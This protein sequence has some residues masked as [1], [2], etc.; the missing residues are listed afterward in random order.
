MEELLEHGGRLIHYDW[1]EFFK[2]VSL[3][4]L[5]ILFLL[6]IYDR[7]VQ[8]HNQLLIN[9][10]LIGRMRYLFTMLREP[11]RQYFGDEKFY[12]SH[13]KIDWV[14]KA[15]YGKKLYYSF[16]LTK[17][18]KKETAKFV[19][20]NM[21]LNQSEVDENFQVTF[22]E[23]QKYPFTTKSIIGRSAMSD[24]SISPEATQ[25]FAKGAYMGNFPINTGEGSLTTNF[26]TTHACS[27][28]MQQKPYLEVHS[29]TF[30][31]KGIYHLTKFFFN[32][33]IASNLYRSLVLAK[34]QE[35]YNF[36]ERVLSFYRVD[37]SQPLSAFP[38]EVC[39]IPD[40]IF[41]MGSGLYGV[42]D[43]EGKFDAL[44]YQKVMRFCK[45]TE[46]KIA[47]G[48]KQTGG[49]L[50]AKKVTEAIAYYRGIPA[51]QDIISPNRFPYAANLTELF[52]FVGTLQSLSKTRGHQ[53][54]HLH[55]S[56][57]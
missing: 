47:Q 52:D 40:I 9:Y 10:P 36:D 25:A 12:D 23:R 22:G 50:L 21:V 49:K 15:S 48:A 32:Q 31:A 2:I 44:R 34:E 51:H 26:L 33:E 54:S 4:L 55:K 37:G 20:A 29:G 18:S 6:F 53:D 1:G 13:E 57:L 5:F 28:D 7:F 35:T 11:M 27:I 56:K 24:G 42:R 3:M 17:A 16:S 38:H 8:R 43:E 19:H 14:N 45:M 41:Q 30:F 39:D 46:I